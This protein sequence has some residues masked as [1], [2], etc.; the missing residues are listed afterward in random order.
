MEPP[1]SWLPVIEA[2][3]PFFSSG[4]LRAERTARMASMDGMIKFSEPKARRHST[5]RPRPSRALVWSFYLSHCSI[6]MTTNMAVMTKSS[7]SVLKVMREP[8]IPP[9]VAPVNQ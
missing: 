8:K 2:A 7:P 9:R 6:N 4:F 3:A 1:L 5:D